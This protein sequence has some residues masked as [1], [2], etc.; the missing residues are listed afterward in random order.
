MCLSFL[1]LLRISFDFEFLPLELKILASPGG[2][3][4]PLALRALVWFMSLPSPDAN[5]PFLTESEA[6][7]V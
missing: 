4:M 7:D 1:S 2:S 3:V 6:R 5:P